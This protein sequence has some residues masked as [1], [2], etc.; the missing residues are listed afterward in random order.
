MLVFV[1]RQ[2]EVGLN[3]ILDSRKWSINLSTETD[4]FLVQPQETSPMVALVITSNLYMRFLRSAYTIIGEVE[5][6]PLS[7]TR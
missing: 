6:L 5:I 3:I 2:T 7:V 1:K 4:V